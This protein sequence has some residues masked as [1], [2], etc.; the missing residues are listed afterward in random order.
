MQVIQWSRA[1]SPVFQTNKYADT[2]C[3]QRMGAL[4]ITYVRIIITYVRIIYYVRTYYLLRTYVLFITY[5]R[6]IITYVRII[7]TYVR[8]KFRFLP[9][10][11]MSPLG[12]RRRTI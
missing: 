12:L 1:F 9:C 3:T 7:I 11:K 2:L 10:R 4:F 5:V 8:I 6:I